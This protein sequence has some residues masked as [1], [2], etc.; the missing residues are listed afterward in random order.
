MGYFYTGEEL[1]H[2]SE[3]VSHFPIFSIPANYYLRHPVSR[4]LLPEHIYMLKDSTASEVKRK[5]L[6]M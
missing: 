2:G 1:K 4:A 5:K 6:E 3:S